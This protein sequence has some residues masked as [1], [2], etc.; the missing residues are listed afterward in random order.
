MRLFLVAVLALASA[1]ASAAVYRGESGSRH[2]VASDD[3][4]AWYDESERL[5]QPLTPSACPGGTCYQ[6][7]A[8]DTLRLQDGKAWWND[9]PLA[10]YSAP[11][12][13]P[14]NHLYA[15]ELPFAAALLADVAFTKTAT[16]QMQDKTLQWYRDPESGLEHPLLAAGYPV[17]QRAALNQYLRAQAL[18]ILAARRQ[19]L[20]ALPAGQ[21][22]TLQYRVTLTPTLLSVQYASF[23]I[24]EEN[25][26][27]TPYAADSGI[28][29]S[30]TAGRGV[31]LEDLFWPNDG[32]PQ[33]L[34]D[35]PAAQTLREQRAQWLH[36]TLQRRAPQAMQG[37]P[38]QPR[39]Y[40]YPYFYL[41]PEG[42]YIG[43]LLPARAA[44]HAHPAGSVIPAA[45]VA[46]HP[47]MLG[48]AALP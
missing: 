45:I 1:H 16:T 47:G 30:L 39:H 31:E 18:N 11:V 7:E 5:P 4:L 3:A 27:G 9:R 48:K 24:H 8:G 6:S 17:A 13:D 12:S 28:S 2:I 29:Y 40:L 35:S 33:P 26:C 21:R 36:D 44:A 38:Y 10:P 41:V 32:T 43:P 37:Y 20:A 25:S 15:S 34:D 22:A 42:I 46:E 23:H 14:N 19:C